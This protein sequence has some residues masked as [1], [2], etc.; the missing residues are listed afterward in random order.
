MRAVDA[1]TALP[2]TLQDDMPRQRECMRASLQ[3]RGGGLRVTRQVRS[4]EKEGN[5]EGG[6]K[7]EAREKGEKVYIMHHHPQEKSTGF[8]G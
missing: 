2:Y 7:R 5:A 3:V 6:G 4:S 8:S 1:S